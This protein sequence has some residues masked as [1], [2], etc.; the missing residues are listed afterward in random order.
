[1]LPQN[2]PRW[3][4]ILLGIALSMLAIVLG[5][6]I[7]PVAAIV[8]PHPTPTATLPAIPYA[9]AASRECEACHFSREALL[10]SADSP[11]LH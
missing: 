2:W 9:R 4:A 6:I 8:Q 11:D 5:Q 1:M 7:E 3:I 10:A